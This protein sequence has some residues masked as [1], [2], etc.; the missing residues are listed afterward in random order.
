MDFYPAFM[1]EVMSSTPI[2]HF[3]LKEVFS[4]L[5][6]KK[7]SK[8]LWWHT[9]GWLATL[10]GLTGGYSTRASF[11]RSS[12]LALALEWG[13]GWTAVLILYILT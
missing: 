9:Q 10:F 2:V 6:F 1:L 13:V 8:G 11:A 7:E 12:G 3:L 5:I 4:Y